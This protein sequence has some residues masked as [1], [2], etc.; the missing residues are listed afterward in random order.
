VLVETPV[1]PVLRE[2]HFGKE[3]L[4]R[5]SAACVFLFLHCMTLMQ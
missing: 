5:Q 2:K 1:P 4:A 3:T